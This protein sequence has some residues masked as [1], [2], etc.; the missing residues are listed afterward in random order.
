MAT[1]WLYAMSAVTT[2]RAFANLLFS[3]LWQTAEEGVRGDNS[4]VFTQ[5]NAFQDSTKPG[6]APYHYVT[7]T[8]MM[9]AQYDEMVEYL[10]GSNPRR[11][12]DSGLVTAGQL[13]AFRDELDVV[14]GDCRSVTDSHLHFLA[15]RN[16]VAV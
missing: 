6:R 2:N 11:W 7:H 8:P 16:L 9:R 15:V 14:I 4:N 3:L 5:E 10:S 13:D 1:K 12:L